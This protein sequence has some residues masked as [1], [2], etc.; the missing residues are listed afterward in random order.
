MFARRKVGAE[1]GLGFLLRRRRLQ[2]FEDGEIRVYG[3]A[4]TSLPARRRPVEQSCP[5][6]FL[7]RDLRKFQQDLTVCGRLCAGHEIERERDCLG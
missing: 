7:R 6:E 2:Q 4:L 5:D 1:T 3:S